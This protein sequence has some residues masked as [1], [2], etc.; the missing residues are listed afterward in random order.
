MVSRAIVAITLLVAT[1]AMSSGVEAGG[2]ASVRLVKGQPDP[3]VGQPWKAALVVKQHDRTEVDVDELSVHFVHQESG[4]SQDTVGV[5][6]G[7]LGHYQ[8]EVVFDKPG[9]WNW[10]ATPAP[11]GPMTMASLQVLETA[12]SVDVGTP[13]VKLSLGTCA[14]PEGEIGYL[15]LERSPSVTDGLLATGIAPGLAYLEKYLG[16][17]PISVTVWDAAGPDKL[18]ACGEVPA[19][20][21]TTPV[22]VVLEPEKGSDTMGTL[23][24]GPRS[25]GITA[26]LMI[27]SEPARGVTI[28]ITDVSSGTFEPGMITI[29]VGTT[30]T[31]VNESSMGHT[32]TGQDSGFM[33]SW[34]LDVGESFTQTFDEAGIF[35]YACDPHD[36]MTGTVTVVE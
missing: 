7:Q 35:Q 9:V 33:N 11:F 16:G 36:W 13:S 26:S 25:G 32:V 18:L 29:P 19:S 31:W 20:A 34:L 23:S 4:S 21:L 24:L 22:I 27:V 5:S 30:V 3:I 15:A 10:T 1:L 14:A 12:A 8:I 2:W 6:T 17:G 28:R